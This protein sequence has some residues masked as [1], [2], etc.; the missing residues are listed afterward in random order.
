MFGDCRA[1]TKLKSRA[2][3]L[4]SLAGAS[5]ADRIRPLARSRVHSTRRAR[6]RRPLGPGS[7][8][9]HLIVARGRSG[10][11]FGGTD[12]I[13]GLFVPVEDP[14]PDVSDHVVYA[15]RTLAGFI[16]ADGG[17]AFAVAERHTGCEIGE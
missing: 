1:T 12:L 17:E 13:V 8:A 9:H 15:I 5:E 11:I 4:F 6:H 16:A 14:F 10:R 2:L 3:W 7:A